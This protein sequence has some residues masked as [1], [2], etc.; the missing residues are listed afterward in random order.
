[1][2]S[3]QAWP[4]TEHAGCLHDAQGTAAASS[5]AAAPAACEVS[6]A[7]AGLTLPS[8][9]SALSEDFQALCVEES[10]HP[11]RPNL[12]F[13]SS[14]R[15]SRAFFFEFIIHNFILL[16]YLFTSFSADTSKVI[17]A[18]FCTLS[19]SQ[20]PTGTGE[21]LARQ[22]PRSDGRHVELTTKTGLPSWVPAE[23]ANDAGEKSTQEDENEQRVANRV[24][25]C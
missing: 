1:M 13:P 5:V 11:A 21:I 12:L 6:P 14:T 9:A 16:F 2:E 3:V 15:V 23:D 24:S 19:N 18:R 8:P 10:T 22:K 4:Q 20:H 25:C 7:A 17:R